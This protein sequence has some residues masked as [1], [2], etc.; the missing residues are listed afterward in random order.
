M[1]KA[2]PQ[3][4]YFKGSPPNLSSSH[5]L[6]FPKASQKMYACLKLSSS[7]AL[8][9]I[10]GIADFLVSNG[11]TIHYELHNKKLS[12]TGY[13]HSFVTGLLLLQ[14]G[15][16]L[17]H[18]NSCIWHNKHIA[19][20]GDSGSGKSSLAAQ[21]HQAGALFFCDEII[22]FDNKNNNILPGF[23]F[24]RLWKNDLDF[25]QFDSL[26]TSKLWDD[27]EK[28]KLDTS[29]QKFDQESK[30]DFLIYLETD[31]TLDSPRIE[32]VK[33]LEKV[34]TFWETY[35]HRPVIEA[36]ALEQQ[37]NQQSFTILQE[38]RVFKLSRPSQ[39]ESRLECFELVK[40]ALK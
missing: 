25:N 5:Q 34:K 19:F 21:F 27:E 40:K 32:E 10:D 36:M 9:K 31:E 38:L 20:C 33:G 8:L 15:H 16:L 29:N 12:F 11:E 24:L 35:Y 4:A 26:L 1:S 22:C 30:L 13:L 3:A 17:L 14:R 39:S 2:C 37:F 6:T 23:P 18:G 28:Y 7:K